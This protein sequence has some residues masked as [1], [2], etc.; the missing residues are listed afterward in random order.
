MHCIC[1]ALFLPVA[2]QSTLHLW[3]NIHPFMHAFTPWRRSQPRRATASWSGGVRVR[4]S[5]SATPRH[6]EEGGTGG[7]TSN[8][9]VTSQP[10]LP[11]KPHAAQKL[12]PVWPFCAVCVLQGVLPTRYIMRQTVV[13]FNMLSNTHTLISGLRETARLPAPQCRLPSSLL[14]GCTPLQE[15]QDTE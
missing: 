3:P 4:V 6:S 14:T 11:P 10:A 5:R 13:I 12:S 1:T 9:Q 15:T 7:Q 8:L 2:T